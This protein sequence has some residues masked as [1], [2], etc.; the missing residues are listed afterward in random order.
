MKFVVVG[1]V[2]LLALVVTS[3]I[4]IAHL[5]SEKAKF[6]GETVNC[7]MEQR[8]RLYIIN[9]TSQDYYD[10]QERFEPA[11]ISELSIDC[12]ISNLSR[13][14][15]N[16][17]NVTGLTWQIKNQFVVGIKIPQTLWRLAECGTNVSQT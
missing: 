13:Q 3:L 15:C 1:C 6:N 14:A 9:G 5:E 11:S 8:V 10:Q 12:S 7:L 2:I 16:A 17:D 4:I